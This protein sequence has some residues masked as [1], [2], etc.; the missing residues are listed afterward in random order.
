MLK[1]CDMTTQASCV[2]ETISKSDWQTVT[3][4]FKSNWA[5]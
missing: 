4:N 1:Q 5:K 2:L 3:S